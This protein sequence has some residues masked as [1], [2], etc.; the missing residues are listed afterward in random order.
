ML[1]VGSTSKSL[2]PAVRLGWIA[3][4]PALL[5]PLTEAKRLA[6]RQTSPIDQLALADAAGQWGL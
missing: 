4:P 6:D 3:C 2:G 5:E 1:Y